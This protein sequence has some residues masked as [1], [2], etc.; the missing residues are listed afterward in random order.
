MRRI[1][2]APARVALDRAMQAAQ[3]AG[4]PALV[5]EVE[6]ALRLLNAPAARL[7]ARDGEHLLGLSDVEELLASNAL[8]IDACRNVARAGTTVVH[9]TGR[10]VLFALART[11]AEAW[12]G[13]V[14]REKLIARV[15][16]TRH[17]D[18]SHRGR[19]RVEIAR[20]RKTLRPLAGV[21]ATDRGFVLEPRAA[22]TA[23]VLAPPVEDRHA[24][25]LSLLADNTAWSSSALALALEVSPRTIQRALETLAETGKVEPF[26]HGRARRWV[27]SNVPGFPTALLLPAPLAQA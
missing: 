23:A 6:A 2:A 13:D 10:P 18:E 27:A 20:L 7:I 12:P 9:I 19:L 14:S 4:I 24:R 17:I 11:L 15:F 5:T 26:G 1:R 21:H 3:E 25:V 16:R 8:L 22:P